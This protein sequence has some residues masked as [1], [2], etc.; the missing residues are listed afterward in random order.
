MRNILLVNN[1]FKE[2]TVGMAN[3][4]AAWLQPYDVKVDIDDGWGGP[5][6]GPYDLIISLGGDGTMLRAARRYGQRE[7]PILGVNMGTVGSM[8][9]ILSGELES[10]IP[11]LLQDQYSLEHRLMLSVRIYADEQL[12][13]NHCALNE[14][15]IKARDFRL[16]KLSVQLQGETQYEYRGDGLMVATPTGST[17]YSLS[18]GGPL[19]HPALKAVLLTPVAP[20]LIAW[21]PMV[22]PEDTTITICPFPDQD[23]TL[24]IDGQIHCNIDQI[25]K[26]VV[27]RAGNLLPLVKMKEKPFLFVVNSRLKSFGD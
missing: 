1:R 11:A 23:L 13:Y 3:Q 14:A 21:K 25:Q 8:C 18:A 24:T 12:M 27:E 6:A 26:I 5:L 7:V 10:F 17:A 9:N 20:N 4:V 19:L 2:H 22:V 16:I 15:V